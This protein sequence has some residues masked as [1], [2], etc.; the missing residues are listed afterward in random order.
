MVNLGRLIPQL[1]NAINADVSRL[2]SNQA[3]QRILQPG[4]KN[5]KLNDFFE[6]PE[7]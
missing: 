6:S 7:A 3:P 1:L 5:Q 4:R 2:C